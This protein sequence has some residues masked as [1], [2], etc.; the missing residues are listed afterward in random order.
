MKKTAL[1]IALLAIGTAILFAESKHT[2]IEVCGV[3][4]NYDSLFNTNKEYISDGFDY[5]VGPPNAVGYYDAQPFTRNTHLGEDWNGNGGGNTDLGDPV[6]AAANGYVTEVYDYGGGWGNVIRIVH[7]L[8]NGR[9][10]ETLYAHEK[11]VYVMQ[12]S[13]VKRGTKIGIMGNLDG[14]MYAHVHFEMRNIVG[15]DLGGG[16]SSDTTGYMSPKLF[17]KA[18]RPKR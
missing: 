1:L 5:P 2:T 7:K 11:D 13:F 3:C 9:C 18:N 14:K 4:G 17:I 8:P 16:Y 10:I 15:M 12:G 6:Y